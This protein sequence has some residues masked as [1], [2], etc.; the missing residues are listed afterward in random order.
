M[1]DALQI[2]L[3]IFGD[4][5]DNAF[6]GGLVGNGNIAVANQLVGGN[7]VQLDAGQTNILVLQS[8]GVELQSVFGNVDGAEIKV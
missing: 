7:S 8:G 5:G 3:A 4:D 1:G 2:G 6:V